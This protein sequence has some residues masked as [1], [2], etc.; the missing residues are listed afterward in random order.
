[1]RKVMSQTAGLVCLA[2]CLFAPTISV[3]QFIALTPGTITTI[4]GT[5]TAAESSNGTSASGGSGAIEP[6]YGLALSP[7][8]DIYFAESTSYVKVIYEGGS[9]AQA[10]LNANGVSSP[11]LGAIYTIVGT[12]TATSGTDEALS[13]VSGVSAPRGLAVDVNGNL[14]I[15]DTGNNKIRVVY[16]GGS[17]VAS[18]IK[19]ENSG[20]T[21][22]VGYIYT[23]AGGGSS[24]FG[25]LGTTVALS[26]PRGIWADNSSNIYIADYSNNE[27]HVLY[28]GGS[29]ASSLIGLEN[30]GTTATVGYVYNIAGNKTS[31]DAGDGALAT[32]GATVGPSAVAV[33][34]AGNVY[35]AE[36]GANK[37][38]KV[39]ATNGYFSTIGGSQTAGNATAGNT[40]D[41]GQATAASF[42]NPRGIWVDGGGNL[43][44]ADTAYNTVPATDVI[45]KIDGNG[46]INTIA[47][48][49]GT[50]GFAGDGGNATSAQLKAPFN[51]VLDSTGN[52][53]IADSYNYRIRK[54][55]VSAANAASNGTVGVYRGSF[56]FGNVSIN[57]TSSGTSAT[58]SNIS[59]A[60][61][62][63]SSISIPAKF[64][65]ITG[66]P[67]AGTADCSTST[68]IAAG[69]S[70]ALD[71]AFAPT[72]T[73]ANTGIAT[74]TY[75]SGTTDTLSIALSGTGVP[76]ATTTTLSASPSAPNFGQSITLTATVTVA[77]GTPTGTI[78][79]YDGSTAISGA[80][81]LNASGVATYSTSTLSAT[82][83]S[84]SA[85]YTPAMGSVFQ[86]S[87]GYLTL[88]VTNNG[89]TSTTV[90]T[91]SKS[92]AN[93]GQSITFTA[94][95]TSNGTQ[96]T[97]AV[98]FYANG[99]SLGGG[100]LTSGVATLVTSTLP[101]GTNT[102]NASYGG[103]SNNL[104]SVSSAVTVT[105]SALRFTT[106][107]GIITTLIGT[108][109][110]GYMG[111][112][113]AANIALINA[114]YS[115]R[116]DNAGN[117]YVSDANNTVR[118]VNASNGNI[119]TFAGTDTACANATATCGDG[120]SAA[121]AQLNAARGLSID[122][123]GDVFISDSG[124]NRIRVV[125]N[126]GASVAAILSANSIAS[127]Q[128]G[129]IYSI[130]GTGATAG[131][132]ATGTLA[133]TQVL[134]SPRGILVDTAGDLYIAEL[135]GSRI[136]VVYA[137]GAAAAS[138]I[139]L[140]NPTVLTPVVGSMYI[141]AGTGTSADSGDS[142]LASAA[143]VDY[144]AEVAI[145]SSNN[146]Y[147]AEFGAHK[148][149]EISASTGFAYTIA[150]TGTAG[151]AGDGGAAS[152][153]E[154]NAPR[155]IWID[156]AGDLYVADTGNLRIR[157]IDGSGK[158]STVAG[159]ASTTL[160]DGGAATSAFINAP[161]S[162]ALDNSGNLLIADN[163]NY[164]VRSV[165]AASALIAFQ[166]I[167][168]NSTSSLQATVS[169]IGQQTVTLSGISIPSGFVQTMASGGT[170]CAGTTALISAASCIVQISF[171]PTATI[172]STGT[173][174][175]SSNAGNASI[176][177]SGTGVASV[178]TT[179]VLSSSTTTPGFGSS[180][181]FT[182]TVSSTGGTPSG[183]VTF[184]D[185]STLLS[186]QILTS[187]VATYSTSSLGIGS[188][189]ITAV[190]SGI[191]T[192]GSSTSSIVTVV[193]I[194]NSVSST[195]T[196][197]VAPTAITYGQTVT[198][199]VTV[200]SIATNPPSGTVTISDNG[201][202]IAT[203]ALVNGTV[204]FVTTA[205]P[206]GSNT[207]TASYPGD[208]NNQASA[209][210]PVI[211]AVTA[212]VL[213]IGAVPG[214]ISTVINTAGTAGSTGNG[215]KAT[216]ATL[217]AP[218]VTRADAS[219]NLYV[220][221]STN[222]V[223]VV[224]TTTSIIST[225]AGTGAAGFSGDSGAASTATLN[226]VRGLA[227]D[228]SGNV[229]IADTGNTRIRMVYAGGTAAAALLSAEGITTPVA[230][231]IY[232][233]AGGGSG[234]AN[235]LAVNQALSSP[236]GVFVD[237][238][239]NI[240][241]A[242]ITGNKVRVVFVSG[243]T[244]SN[245][246]TLENPT[247]VTPVV[248]DMYVIAG[249]GSSTYSGDAGL[250]TSAGIIYPADIGFDTVGNLYIAE[251]GGNRIR[252]VVAA[253][254]VITTIAGS[255]TGTAGFT[256]DGA[257]AAAAQLNTPR[258]IWVDAGGNIYIADTT[259]NRIRMINGSGTITSIAGG[260]TLVG[261]AG[262]AT[263]ALL[264]APYSVAFDN[265][266]N[267]LIATFG[268][269]RVR[270]VNAVSSELTYGSIALGTTSA[271]QNLTVTN[272]GG[273]NVTLSGINIPAGYMQT[274]SGA[275]DC[276]ST[277]SLAAGA[278]CILQL[279]FA[280]SAAVA[281]PAS[282]TV[283]SNAATISVVL[284]GTGVVGATTTAL[285]VSTTSPS[286]GNNVTFSA[287]V[288][289]VA[290]TPAGIISFYDGTTLLS[291]QTLTAGA[292]S[293]STS[294][295][296]VGSHTI[297][298]AYGGATG[299]TTSTSAPVVV[300]VAGNGAASTTV[301][302]ASPTIASL[303]QS[304]TFTVAVTS[305]ASSQPTGTVSIYDNGTLLGT[306]NLISGVATYSTMA[307]L[308]GSNAVTASYF[309]DANNL[310]SSSTTVTV[311]VSVIQI[312]A[313]PGVI[314]TVIGTGTSGL[315][316][317]GGAATS[318]TISGPYSARS[319]A[320][321]DLYVADN[322][323]T[324]RKVTASTG[325][326]S[327]FAGTGTAGSSGDGGAATFATLSAPR[328]LAVDAAGDLF[329]SDTG[330]NK[331]R[332]VYEGG[333]S[334][335][336]LLS[337]EGVGA[338]VIGNIYTVAGGGTGANGTQANKQAL[339]SPRGL[340]I[341]SFGNVYIADLNNNRVRI[342]YVSG[343][344]AASL[345][346]LENPT[347]LTPAVGA[348]Y[349]IAGI[350]S[351]TDSGDGGVASAAGVDEP[352]DVGLDASGNLYLVEYGGNR[353]RKVTAATGIISTI[354]GIGTPGFSGDNGPALAAQF[355]SPRDLWVDGGGN[356]YIA[357]TSNN[358]IRKIDGSGTITTIVGGG[359]T[360]GD[361]GAATAALLNQP[362]SIAFDNAGNLLIASNGDNRVRSVSATTSVLAFPNTTVGST[363]TAQSIMLAN[364]GGQAIIPSVFSIPSAFTPVSGAA[365]DCAVATAI[366]PGASC[367]LRISFSPTL[368]G[369]RSG[370][371]TVTTNASNSLNGVVSVQMSALGVN[372]HTVGSLVTLATIPIGGA[373]D[374]G[375]AL[376]LTANVVSNGAG[377]NAVPSGTVTFFTGQQALGTATL[378]L[379]GV[380]TLTLTTF[381]LGS[382]VVTAVYNGDSVYQP[383]IASSVTVTIYTGP[384]DFVMSSASGRTN[385]GTVAAGQ[386]AY[387]DLSITSTGGFDQTI[388][389]SCSGLPANATCIFTPTYLTPV[390]G[391]SAA[392]FG[393][394]I[395]TAI[396]NAPNGPHAGLG[397]GPMLGRISTP[398]L[399][400]IFGAFFLPVGLR[401]KLR[402][403]FLLVLLSLCSLAAI[404][405]CN[406]ASYTTNLTPTG[407]YTITVNA[408][409][410]T[411]THSMTE[412]LTVQ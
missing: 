402:S 75:T 358:R 382:S 332:M 129:Y 168:L 317:N 328:G 20:T 22:T 368:S 322:N 237:S 24:A 122:T 280:P 377:G 13:T 283:I 228:S 226:A 299:F 406:S 134:N 121:S 264:N 378:S 83:H 79:F 313:L 125:Y 81:S 365:T 69:T 175:V 203:P 154:L 316:G 89:A 325:I 142:A 404:T 305:S 39:S 261:D 87:V 271:G 182:A 340:L 103:D 34:V 9:A 105:V 336:A 115:V 366:A 375:Q 26:S 33:D 363:S 164:R 250:A 149:R 335:A 210:A 279:A 218:Y 233:I 112:G 350:S 304:V 326:I 231:N 257:A 344:S 225:L 198:L 165:S 190:Y 111:D 196:L 174:T 52:L 278:S 232:T 215:G 1:M 104:A 342:I 151:F 205:L 318:A 163:G 399:A 189:F 387:Y 244:V 128:V 170:N 258:G 256:G 352:T 391:A 229:Y 355:N 45:R 143:G 221:D 201:T 381:P 108:G 349:S 403:T 133:T 398:L 40:G 324:V 269:N 236:R 91:S 30:S 302:S 389:F 187:G 67:I 136:R 254:G 41:G 118:M 183:T 32:S 59:D 390:I 138:L 97:G 294:T 37:I 84:L 88:S 306:S 220:S 38:R 110:K 195:T 386:T 153:A 186:T 295:L 285:S 117:L 270:S 162:V 199:T 124:D 341:D 265:L 70:C 194:N 177:L 167:T 224:N 339:S 55:S 298:A 4:A 409:A 323:N 119:S 17:S 65:Q 359:S 126:G 351:F 347:V 92:S 208:P 207:I 19:I 253:T 243:T 98:T 367:N 169:N 268:D 376:T 64:I 300:V 272:T 137:G 193:V 412:T 11:V 241:I 148:I 410:G 384:G 214:V 321:G 135:S 329:I 327:A 293:F 255:T 12:G 155:G 141:L 132:A 184:Y 102:I 411:I 296:T 292:V 394:S 396:S 8:G 202:V 48:T 140:E 96:P 212:S 219:G 334:T 127:P 288:T 217:N 62:T 234:A 73:G 123:A 60:S 354:A 171:T 319:D 44:I 303:G 144:P 10:I 260:G 181:T 242:D 95:V 179:T 314:A 362:H 206:L 14:Y 53:Y 176:A 291:T 360:T 106:S 337:A 361:A 161:Y 5:G 47:G 27:V 343:S 94:T 276:T 240:F 401:R 197:T 76:V 71:L 252:K 139:T 77:S 312:A 54:V 74:V 397:D 51:V 286:V 156:W 407:T 49:N 192:F 160:G 131:G 275:T 320:S 101:I 158:I 297:T 247:V 29:A 90:L 178:S 213:R 166:T 100:S 209:A 290:G 57:T 310:A 408:V 301:F 42:D 370:T 93:L 395:T 353:V 211:I 18:L 385:S 346:T 99:N 333:S 251:F 107:P 374:L 266:G 85:Y 259:N 157:K 3:A 263:S 58:V 46:Y 356:I 230:G 392:T 66:S 36:Y 23:L 80:V 147:I 379:S 348:M 227:I 78:V 43:Y 267:L 113:G 277:T 239:G 68:P 159:S 307:L 63:L 6:L 311:N 7:S 180:V 373:V 330:N 152:A 238:L 82:S 200:A 315:T 61:L 28:N 364:T 388:T 380:A 345:I 405:G 331:V 246:I 31:I 369:I 222:Q 282:A 393:L 21:A 16:A 372:P 249:S 150:G 35:I 146:V 235:T 262:P 50:V 216:A 289:S 25:S 173:A 371:A 86:S 145:D 383:S 116:S 185:G 287:A 223:R 120:A 308:L 56:A 109:T 114:P 281:Y 357:D 204:S 274:A 15:S 338:P 188:H 191:S 172:T 245:L 309:G 400:L 2:V 72:S 248:G 273:Q 130:A 284:S